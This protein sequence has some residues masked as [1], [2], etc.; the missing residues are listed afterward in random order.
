MKY[1]CPKN[2]NTSS[3]RHCH[4]AP[5]SPLY[6]L[7]LTHTNLYLFFFFIYKRSGKRRA[8]ETHGICGGANSPDKTFGHFK[9]SKTGS[10]NHQLAHEFD[11]P[12]ENATA[13]LGVFADRSRGTYDDRFA[14]R[15]CAQPA[16]GGQGDRGQIANAVLEHESTDK[17]PK[18]RFAHH[19][20]C[21]HRYSSASGRPPR[22]DDQR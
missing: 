19:R 10:G 21:Q 3:P 5:P 12:Q 1:V 11:V 15:R 18:L 8:H 2:F 6:W 22:Y 7:N 9:R 16:D 4:Y 20:R 13:E 14:G 17:R